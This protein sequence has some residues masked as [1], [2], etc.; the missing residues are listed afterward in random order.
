MQVTPEL[1]ELTNKFISDFFEL[2]N[3]QD[4]TRKRDDLYA[5]NFVLPD[6][7]AQSNYPK[8]EDERTILMGMSSF[9]DSIAKN[10][11]NNRIQGFIPIIEKRL[12]DADKYEDVDD[13][14]VKNIIT[15][16]YLKDD[17]D[18]IFSLNENDEHDFTIQKIKTPSQTVSFDVINNRSGFVGNCVLY[19]SLE[20]VFINGNDYTTEMITDEVRFYVNNQEVMVI[21]YSYDIK[22]DVY[23]EKGKFTHYKYIADI[24]S[25]YTVLTY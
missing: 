10:M 22:N 8:Y 23:Y 7:I 12:E 4:I 19:K 25:F 5:F 11:F 14:Y 1:L 15:T 2:C 9:D 17:E 21:R 13:Y 24:N 6:A 18:F 20:K 3:K 16:D